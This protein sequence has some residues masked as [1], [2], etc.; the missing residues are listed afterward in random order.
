MI[1]VQYDYYNFRIIFRLHEK[2]NLLKLITEMSKLRFYDIFITIN[3]SQI[4]CNSY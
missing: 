4:L 3:H 1:Y 2:L